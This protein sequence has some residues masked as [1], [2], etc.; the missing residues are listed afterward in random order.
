[1]LLWHCQ[2]LR[3]AKT[4]LV[5]SFTYSCPPSSS[6]PLG[7]L[8]FLLSFWISILLISES[9]LNLFFVLDLMRSLL[10]MHAL[11]LANILV[12]VFV[13]ILTVVITFLASAV[14]IVLITFCNGA[15]KQPCRGHNVSELDA[16]ASM[17][18]E[19]N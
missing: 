2:L 16:D 3:H 11:I 14:R 4:L 12:L 6:F 9:S 19:V 17:Y 10:S 8:V 15:F 5:F 13:V 1:M 18:S 7:H